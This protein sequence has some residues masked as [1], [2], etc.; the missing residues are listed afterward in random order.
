[1]R[2]DFLA[3]VLQVVPQINFT[4]VLFIEKNLVRTTMDPD[5]KSVF[6]KTIK[7]VNFLN[8]DSSYKTIYH[9]L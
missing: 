2:K 7:I 3:Q 9:S 1:M 5:L 4:L 6:D 8:R